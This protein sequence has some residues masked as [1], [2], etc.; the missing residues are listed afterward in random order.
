MYHPEW[1]ATAWE[2]LLIFYAV[3][4][5]TFV[6]VAFGNRVLPYV[7]TVASAWNGITILIVLISTLR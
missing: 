3:C 2:L 7:D 4:I 1:E 6:I 5:G